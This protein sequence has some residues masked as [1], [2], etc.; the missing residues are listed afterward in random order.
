MCF[1]VASCNSTVR[2]VLRNNGK[3]A[4][5]LS[6]ATICTG[7]NYFTQPINPRKGL[8]LGLRPSRERLSAG[9]LLSL[10]NAGSNYCT[11][12]RGQKDGQG[13]STEKRWCFNRIDK[14]ETKTINQ[15][16]PPPALWLC[17][18]LEMSLHL[19]VFS[20]PICR[21]EIILSQRRIFRV[22]SC[23]IPKAP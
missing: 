10:R 12:I 4:G 16:D 18:T 5:Y 8:H 13:E 1:R 11:A 3:S 22:N 15:W 19:S 2:S 17:V 20:F 14:R 9:V 7:K 21:I 23:Q 6:I